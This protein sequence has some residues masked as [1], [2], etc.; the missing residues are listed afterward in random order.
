MLCGPA[1]GLLHDIYAGYNP[2]GPFDNE[3]EYHNSMTGGRLKWLRSTYPKAFARPHTS[4]FT[5]GDL[6][7]GNILVDAGKFTGLIDWERSGFY[8]EYWENTKA[9]MGSFDTLEAETMWKRIWGDE[10]VDEVAMSVAWNSSCPFGA[11]EMEES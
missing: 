1:G 5:H 10:Y 4:A 2:C 9:A 7:L 8:P 11:P 3:D 6:L